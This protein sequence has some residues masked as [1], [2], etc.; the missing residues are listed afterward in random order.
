MRAAIIGAGFAGRVHAEALAACGVE[1]AAIITTKEETAEAF[2][3]EYGIPRWGTEL[4][5]AWEDDIDAVHICTPP[6]THG[7]MVKELL[8]HGKN[9]LCE[10]PLSF[11]AEEA[12]EIARI[13]GE[14]GRIC[15]LTFNVR[16]H[17]AVQKAREILQSG[18]FGRPLLIHGN[19]MQEF[20]A[21]PAPLDWRY[22]PELAGNMRAVSEIGSHW[23][24]LAQYVSGKKVTAVSALFGNFH[25]HRILADGMMY[26]EDSGV[27]GEDF[28]VISEDAAA[29]T[30]RYEDGAMGN[31]LLSEISPG[32]GNRLSLEITCQYGN[33]WW[34]EEDNNILYTARKGEGVCMEVFA[35]GNGFTDTFRTLLSNYYK[36]V[37]DQKTGAAEGK[38]TNAAG[39]AA[40][41][42]NW[43]TFEEGAQVTAVCCAAA[44]SAAADSRWVEV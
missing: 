39:V 28:S 8:K 9:V 2:A 14:S 33:L 6:T 30:F 13:A 42:K 32:R 31:V 19:Y 10:K 21:F 35:F 16:Y 24:D 37:A 26:P 36:A 34:N 44:E 22:K 43:P 23:I 1:I 29:L 11:D 18:D 7:W 3:R 25:P 4:S 40:A 17:M 27:K 15:A 41:E 20:N 38:D 12:E 5:L